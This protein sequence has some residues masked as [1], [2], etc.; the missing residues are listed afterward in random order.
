MM[1]EII[2]WPHDLRLGVRTGAILRQF[3]Y[4]E[5]QNTACEPAPY[6]TLAAIG[7][8]MTTHGVVAARFVDLGSGLGR[9]LYFFA[10]RFEELIGYEVV[11]EVQSM[12][13][14]QLARVRARRP[15]FERIS[16]VCADATTSAP[17]DQPLVLF[18][19]NPFGQKPMARL[20]ERLREARCEVH[21][22]Y[23]NPVLEGM[24]TGAVGPPADVFRCDFPVAYFHLD[25]VRAKDSPSAGHQHLPLK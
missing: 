1:R 21:L 5:L 12:A 6:R 13:A 17:L 19:Y 4:S 3:A 7:R 22:Y 9:P 10:P 18:M 2:D 23:V 24:I 20:C 8:H 15:E 25:S 11:A 16:L 14:E